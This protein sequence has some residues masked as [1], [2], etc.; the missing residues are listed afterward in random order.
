MLTLMP[1]TMIVMFVAMKKRG[2]AAQNTST[3]A[4]SEVMAQACTAAAARL[5]M[6][7]PEQAALCCDELPHADEIMGV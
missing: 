7:D 3:Q 6:S 4:D 2:C 1:A 5:S